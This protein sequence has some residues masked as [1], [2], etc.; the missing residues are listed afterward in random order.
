MRYEP[1]HRVLAAAALVAAVALPLAAHAQGTAPAAPAPAPAPAPHHV[2]HH[3][4]HHP[5]HTPVAGNPNGTGVA[6]G[7]TGGQ[8]MADEPLPAQPQAEPTPSQ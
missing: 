3:G 7:R 4:K 2:K 5:S 8:P 1:L 6:N